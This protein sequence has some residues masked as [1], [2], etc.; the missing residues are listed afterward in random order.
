M[1]P[2]PRKVMAMRTLLATIAAL[3]VTASLAAAEGQIATRAELMQMLGAYTTDDYETMDVADGETMNTG[4]TALDATTVVDGQGPGLVHSGTTY[5]SIR[6]PFTWVGNNYL[7][8]I[9]TRT[10]IAWNPTEANPLEPQLFFAITIHFDEKPQA[11]GV[12][13][14]RFGEMGQITVEVYETDD[15][16]AQE[17]YLPTPVAGEPYFFGFFREGGLTDVVVKNTLFGT[18]WSPNIDNFTYGVL[19]ATPAEPTSWG[20]IKTLYR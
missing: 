17:F 5:T 20:R 12:D 10:L 19:G 18:I 14:L 16:F 2:P 9:P 11:F 4:L 3:L 15:A 8:L 7:D 13:I 1:G 6:G